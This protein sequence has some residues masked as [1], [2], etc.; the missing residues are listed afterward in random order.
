MKAL[1]SWIAPYD[2]IR[3]Q[4]F[5][6]LKATVRRCS[7]DRV[8]SDRLKDTLRCPPSTKKQFEALGVNYA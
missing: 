7:Q 4:Q 8:H 5:A 2:N 6:Q 3:K 1:N